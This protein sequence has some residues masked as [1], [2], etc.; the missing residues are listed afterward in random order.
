MALTLK[1]KVIEKSPY[2]S[3]R[4]E[5][6]KNCMYALYGERFANVPFKYLGINFCVVVW[7]EEKEV[8]EITETVEDHAD[9]FSVG[10]LYEINGVKYKILNIVHQ[11]ASDYT[12]FLEKRIR[13]ERTTD[14]LLL[15]KKDEI[16]EVIEGW[17]KSNSSFWK[18]LKILLK[19]G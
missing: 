15:E 6:E 5:K 7:I 16:N 3:T 1:Q 8:D 17:K 9:S 12:L 11:N 4:I 10:N 19:H 18:K 13:N 2:I 14:A